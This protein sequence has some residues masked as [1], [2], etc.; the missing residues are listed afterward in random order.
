MFILMF[1]GRHICRFN[2]HTT[3]CR[4]EYVCRYYSFAGSNGDI[5]GIRYVV[6]GTLMAFIATYAKRWLP[7]MQNTQ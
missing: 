5:H 1:S 3:G 2:I 7:L 6:V 4:L